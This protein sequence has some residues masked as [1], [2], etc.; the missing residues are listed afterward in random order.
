MAMAKI[1]NT[2]LEVRIA[3]RTERLPLSRMLELY[4]HDLSDIWDQDLDVHGEYGYSLDAFWRPGPCKPFVFLVDGKYA[5]FA[6]VDDD[7]CLPENEFW[8]A[9]FCVLRKYRRSGIGAAAAHAIFDLVRG[10][11]EVGQMPRNLAAQKFWRQVIGTYSAGSYTEME[12]HD[13]RWDGF[14]Q[15]FDNSVAPDSTG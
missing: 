3:A 2:S 1:V 11:W 9:Q 10:R 6:L 15:C 13:A 7:V 8:M 5:G 4:Q 12:L 14:L